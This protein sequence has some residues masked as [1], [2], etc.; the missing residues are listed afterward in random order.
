MKAARIALIGMMGSGKSTVA[1]VL[2]ER[3]DWPLVDLDAVLEAK[4]EMSVSEIFT[5]QGEPAFRALEA[6]SCLA[7]LE[8][9]E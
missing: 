6:S 4:S 5:S 2:A 9:D 7:L 1:A 3:L 8:P